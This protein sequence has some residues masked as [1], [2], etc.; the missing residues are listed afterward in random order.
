MNPTDPTSRTPFASTLILKTPPEGETWSW[1]N[2]GGSYAGCCACEAFDGEYTLSLD[3]THTF[4]TWQPYWGLNKY[5]PT[6]ETR[7]I[8]QAFDFCGQY[9]GIWVAILTEEHTPGGTLYI[10]GDRAWSR[11]PNCFIRITVLNPD[12]VQWA[13]EGCGFSYPLNQW[14]QGCNDP[15][16]PYWSLDGWI[17]N[18]FCNGDPMEL[19]SG[20][21][22]TLC[23]P[24]DSYYSG[25][26]QQIFDNPLP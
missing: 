2:Y 10:E 4:W 13:A 24:Y 6:Y 20:G 17:S 25:T 9:T 19:M 26:I 22:Y 1:T 8:G 11:N 7:W 14:Q 18:D 23:Q 3:C 12:Q 21:G 15:T 16:L 5:M